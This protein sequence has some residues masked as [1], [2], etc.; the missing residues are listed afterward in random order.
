LS[1]LQSLVFPHRSGQ[2]PDR[3]RPVFYMQGA[4]P[5][6]GATRQRVRQVY[7]SRMR[8]GERVHRRDPLSLVLAR[9]P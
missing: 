4:L 3:Q 8:S 1:F 5:F 9:P 6:R 2:P 7:R